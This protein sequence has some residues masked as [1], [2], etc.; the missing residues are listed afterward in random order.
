MTKNQT[1]HMVMIIELEGL[2]RKIKAADKVAAFCGVAGSRTRV[3][4]RNP[5]GFYMLILLLVV[6]RG[7]AKGSRSFPYSLESSPWPRERASDYPGLDGT[8]YTVADLEQITAGY[9]A[10]HHLGRGMKLSSI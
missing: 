8:P 5:S 9:L 10:P 3:Q 2:T 1:N 6:G 4:T 7:L